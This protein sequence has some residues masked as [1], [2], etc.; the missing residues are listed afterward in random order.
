MENPSIPTSSIN[1]AEVTTVPVVEIPSLE[2]LTS[3]IS[4]TNTAESN[5]GTLESRY[6]STTSTIPTETTNS[7]QSYEVDEKKETLSQICDLLRIDKPTGN[8]KTPSQHY[9][10]YLEIQDALRKAYAS[11]VAPGK[12]NVLLAHFDQQSD[13]N[14]D[15][16][17]Y[18]D[19]YQKCETRTGRYTL[20]GMIPKEVSERRISTMF[21]VSRQTVHNG[22]EAFGKYGSDLGSSMETITRDKMSIDKVE[23]FLNFTIDGS[24]LQEEAYGAR[25]IKFDSGKKMEINNCLIMCSRAQVVREYQT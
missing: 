23:H 4:S 1:S 25:T 22:R 5:A 15:L 11:A 3:T 18:M 7:T 21:K 13:K 19:V 6:F 17:P 10:K 16:E 20:L 24:I 8:T 12:E 14:V 2:S 9:E